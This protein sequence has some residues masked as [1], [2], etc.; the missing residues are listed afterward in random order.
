MCRLIRVRQLADILILA[1]E[2]RARLDVLADVL[3]VV[4]P[5]LARQLVGN[6]HGDADGEEQRHTHDGDGLVEHWKCNNI[7]WR[8]TGG[9]TG[10]GWMDQESIEP[11]THCG[12]FRY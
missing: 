4:V 6:G 11:A 10:L 9:L 5:R 7:V 3:D 2:I 1:Q 8:N 12:D